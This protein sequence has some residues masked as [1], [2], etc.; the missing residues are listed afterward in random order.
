MRITLFVK[1]N[2]ICY[3]TGNGIHSKNEDR[4]E[5]LGWKPAGVIR[6]RDISGNFPTMSEVLRNEKVKPNPA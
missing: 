2:K 5:T 6:G 1:D 4:L 3:S